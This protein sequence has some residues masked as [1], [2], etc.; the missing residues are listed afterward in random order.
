MNQEFLTSKSGTPHWDYIR[1]GLGRS[2]RSLSENNFAKERRNWLAILLREVL[3]NALDAKL[4]DVDRVHV[5]IRHGQLDQ[6]SKAYMA[7]LIP[8]EHI[9]RFAQ[10]VPH[11]Q[12]VAHVADVS[13]CLIV[14]DFGTSG[15]TGKTDDP[16]VEGKGQNWNA[17]WFREGEGGKEN[18]S[19]NGGAGQGKITYFS[20]SAI[21]TLFAYTV[22]ADDK[23]GVLLGAS[24]FLRDYPYENL[25]WKRDAYWGI[26]DGKDL[27]RKVLPVQVGD[28]VQ[29]F[30]QRLGLERAPNQSG[31]SLVIPS[32]KE[33]DVGKAAQVVIAE[34]FVPIVRGDLVVSLG[35]TTFDR[36]SIS[37]LAD[38]LLPDLVARQLHT[39]TTK[40][41]RDFLVSAIKKTETNTVF[42]ASSVK[43]A[44]Q[45][46]DST[47]KEEDLVAMRESIQNEDIVSV[48]IPLTI[49]PK[50]GGV[51]DCHFD[52]HLEC[53]F[54]LDQPEQAII[55]KDLLIGEEPIGGGKLRQ[56]ARALTL[57]TSSDLSRL[58]LSAE[59]ATHL[60]WNTRLPRLGEYYTAGHEA[61]ALVRNATVRVLDILTGGDQKK[62]FK[63]LSKYFSVPGV[64]S[65]VQAKG[66]KSPKGKQMPTPNDIPAPEKRVL[67]ME[68]LEDGCRIRP[69]K[70]GAITAE[71]IPIRVKVEFAYEGLDK[72]AF[73][74]YDPLDFNLSDQ[75]FTVSYAGCLV[76]SKHMNVIEFQ[77]YEPDF[78]LQVRGFDKNL[79]LRM[80]MNYEEKTNATAVNAE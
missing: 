22:R 38:Q 50:A 56:R 13:E 52:I 69:S 25:R 12:E 16:E 42:V 55:R 59:E 19:G 37:S 32:P 53:P 71:T 8:P 21:R 80:R 40:G 67:V 76:D 9:D 75:P 43:T 33:F 31:L 72:D 45:L 27:D 79:R 14:E 2:G 20:T 39:C 30:T 26:W 24:S 34:F 48:R 1:T 64:L 66:K 51:L 7:T 62:D 44:A 73:S 74:E 70:A 28:L 41:Y 5:S 6:A 23:T 4:P 58:L 49:K 68:A 3:Q 77:I 35:G 65:S 61:V 36:G 18:S 78:D 11:L 46:S 15:L 63:L 57:I 29:L 10:S 17:F 60:R 54:E 47:F